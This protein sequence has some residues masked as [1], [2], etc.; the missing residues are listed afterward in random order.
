MT[1]YAF[2]TKNARYLKMRI[3]EEA[4][5]AATDIRNLHKILQIRKKSEHLE[6]ATT[7]IFGFDVTLSTEEGDVFRG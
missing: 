4:F 2:S 7:R 3:I 1:G 6:T 5:L